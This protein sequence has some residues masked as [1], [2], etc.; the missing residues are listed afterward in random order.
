MAAVVVVVISLLETE[1]NVVLIGQWRSLIQ[2]HE[3][4]KDQL[5]SASCIA[6]A[7]L[8]GKQSTSWRHLLSKMQPRQPIIEGTTLARVVMVVGILT[9]SLHPTEIQLCRI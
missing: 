4:R 3:A 5:G 1:L 2:V 8:S 6:D 9:I 7:A